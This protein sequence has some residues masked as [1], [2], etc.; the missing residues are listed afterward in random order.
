[1]EVKLIKL[2]VPLCVFFI[3][4]CSGDAKQISFF[5]SGGPH[6]STLK[7][8]PQVEVNEVITNAYQTNTKT[9]WQGFWGLGANHT[10]EKSWFSF[11][12]FSLGIA[13][14]FF[15]LGQVN[16][17]KFPFINEGLFDT[18]NY[19]FH[20][21]SASLMVEGKAIYS[22][23]A[24][25][26]YALVG[27]GPSWNRLY[28]YREK[29]SDLSL[30]AAPSVPFKNHTKQTFSYALGAGL[31]YLLWDDKQHHVQY[32]MTAGY[33]YFNL[34]EGALGYCLAQTSKD[35]LTVKNLYT[36]GVVFTLA[37]SFG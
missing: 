25:K 26:P 8:K 16:G 1:M 13:G 18:L 5:V 35:R 36:Q 11:Y 15:K 7:N 27:I 4:P 14:Y 33:Q 17:T 3:F 22:K 2:V 32:H 21:K 29:P 28:A 9:N 30:S 34:G 12:Q 37:V 31:G 24:L 23:Y 6:F 20:A 19:N 10:F